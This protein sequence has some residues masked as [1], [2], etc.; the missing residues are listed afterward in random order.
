MRER[1]RLLCPHDGPSRCGLAALHS[2][3]VEVTALA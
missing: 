3:P 2:N 1:K